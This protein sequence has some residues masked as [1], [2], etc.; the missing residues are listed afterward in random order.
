MSHSPVTIELVDVKNVCRIAQ[1]TPL[2]LTDAL[3][4]SDG[5]PSSLDMLDRRMRARAD[6]NRIRQKPDK[7][8]LGAATLLFQY[9]RECELGNKEIDSEVENIFIRRIADVTHWP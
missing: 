7:V 5:A 6:L 2:R 4:S 9:R 3:R 8:K 1:I